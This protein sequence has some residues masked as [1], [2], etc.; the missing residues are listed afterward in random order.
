MNDLGALLALAASL[1]REAGGLLRESF[2]RPRLETST[3]TSPTDM[4]TE[5]DLAAEQLIRSRLE[6]ERPGDAI[7]GEEGGDTPGSSG[8][9]WIVDPLDGTTNFLYGIPQWAVSVAVEDPTGTALAGVVYD[10]M[11]DELWTARSDDAPRLD[12]TPIEAS[13]CN[14][15]G[16]AL[17]A[18]GFGYEAGVRARQAEFVS[19]LLPRVRDIRRFGSAAL[20][21]A[22]TAAGRYDAYFE[23]GVQHWDV[24]AGELL[25]RRAGLHLRPLAAAP[26]AGPGVL[27]APGGIADELESLVT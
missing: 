21:L 18:T 17:V 13:T 14:D 6:R 3:K 5:A 11:R 12:G 9:R 1:A 23:R 19:A 27:V 8:L 7:L 16:T 25:C 10:P 4:V 24:A 2:E 20:D 26:P 15:L 22:W